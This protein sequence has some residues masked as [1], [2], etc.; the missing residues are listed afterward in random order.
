MNNRKLKLPGARPAGRCGLLPTVAVALA[1][2]GCVH[3]SHGVD[4]SS[5]FAL[6]GDMPYDGRQ[7]QEFRN[8]IA[9]TNRVPL[10]FVVH[11]GDFW[12]DGLLWK[13]SS[14][15]HA[16]CAD[17]TFADRL[18][19]TQQSRHPYILVPGDN[20]WADCHRAKPESFEPMER[21]AT[22]R[23]TFFSGERSLGQKTLAV[24]R[25]S[26]QAGFRDYRENIRWVHEN[27]QF[28]TLHMI[29][30]NN[31]LGRTVEM[32]E[33]FRQRN[34]ANLAW[35]REA[36]SLA[37][38][39][40][41]RAIMII[42]QANP[43]FENRWPARLQGRYLLDGLG[44]KS[45]ENRRHTGFD[46]FLD[47]LEKETMAFGKPVV[48]AHGDT[49]LYRVD[50]PLTGTS[51]KRII[52]NFTRVETFGYPD[53]HWVRVSIDP[54]DPNVFRFRQEIVNANRVRH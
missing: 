18:A 45:P 53:T 11:T 47:A 8:L 21:L 48:Y 3:G 42:A 34:A 52:E 30:S 7:E 51:S 24:T 44:L 37:T 40:G 14:I 41:R 27:V 12:S 23:K 31:N 22:L 29:G 4:A 35:M 19:V 49:H 36:F 6:I 43:R 54:D 9:A 20:D 2:A 5:D 28:V 25:Q 1:M 26:T 33:E 39:D 10:A 46:E 32:D 50:K 13:D 17:D 38:R 16:P 15:G